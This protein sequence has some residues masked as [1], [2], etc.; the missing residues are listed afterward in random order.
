MALDIR[1]GTL[2][3]ICSFAILRRTLGGVNTS[4]AALCAPGPAETIPQRIQTEFYR[5][6]CSLQPRR[7]ARVSTRMST[8]LTDDRYAEYS[9]RAE[10]AAGEAAKTSDLGMRESWLKVAASWRALAEQ[11]QQM[12]QKSGRAKKHD[13]S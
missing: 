4:Y 9:A 7:F 10:E 8:K 11:L 3:G 12:E 5:K 2:A 6:N 1:G 13:G